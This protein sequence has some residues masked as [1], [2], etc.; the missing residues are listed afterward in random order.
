MPF[1]IGYAG[2]SMLFLSA[3]GIE[4]ESRAVSDRSGRHALYQLTAP[5]PRGGA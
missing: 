4:F 2:M 3:E 1:V 5:A